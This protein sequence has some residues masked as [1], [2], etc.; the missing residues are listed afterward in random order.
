MIQPGPQY[1]QQN[2]S[3]F[4]TD[5]ETREAITV[6]TDRAVEGLLLRQASD[7]AVYRITVVAGALTATLV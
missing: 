5:L 3:L 1:S 4:R 7:G 2:E 6:R